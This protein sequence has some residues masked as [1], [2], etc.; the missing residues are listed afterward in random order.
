VTC[1]L[2][3]RP[4]FRSCISIILS[5]HSIIFM[6]VPPEDSRRFDYLTKCD[7]TTCNLAEVC[8]R[9]GVNLLTP[10]SGSKNKQNKQDVWCLV[11]QKYLIS[12]ISTTSS[13]DGNKSSFR[14]A[15]ICSEYQIMDNSI[16]AII[17]T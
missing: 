5:L 8:R 13:V 4:Y 12:I 6:F 3:I 16:T 14:N 2:K 15:M 7:V 9:F 1:F 10:Y 11:R 17:Q